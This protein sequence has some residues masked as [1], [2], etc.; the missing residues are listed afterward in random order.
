LVKQWESP[1]DFVVDQLRMMRP[2]S[3]RILEDENL[4]HEYHD[5]VAGSFRN[6][7][8][9]T[10]LP[11]WG[12]KTDFLG[13]GSLIEN[14]TYDLDQQQQQSVPESYQRRVQFTN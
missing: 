12:N 10:S 7:Y 2:T 5:Q 1:S 8:A 14:N 13:K 4:L 6:F 9:D 3:L 11:K